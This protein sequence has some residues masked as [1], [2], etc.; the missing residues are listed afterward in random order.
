MD[1]SSGLLYFPI[2]SSKDFTSKF[3]GNGGLPN[4]VLSVD[5]RAMHDKTAGRIQQICPNCKKSTMIKP[6]TP[7]EAEPRKHY[8]TECGHQWWEFDTRAVQRTDSRGV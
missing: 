4:G 6:A 2:S 7:D 5:V 8:C 3:S 1:A